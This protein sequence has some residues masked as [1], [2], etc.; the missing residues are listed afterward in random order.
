MSASSDS[1]SESDFP[2]TTREEHLTEIEEGMRELRKSVQSFSMQHARDQ[3][4]VNPEVCH[5]LGQVIGQLPSLLETHNIIEAR[6]VLRD[7]VWPLNS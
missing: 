2:T 3:Y 1:D 6:C 5:F 7:P 4:T